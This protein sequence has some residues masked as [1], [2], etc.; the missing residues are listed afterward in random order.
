MISYEGDL[1]NDGFVLVR[2]AV[3]KKIIKEIY[4]EIISSQKQVAK[5][6]QTLKD[7]AQIKSGLA[8]EKNT[9]KYLKN[10]GV[11]FRS[12]NKILQLQTF[13]FAKSIS[14]NELYISDIELHQ[15]SPGVSGTPPHQDNFYFGLKLSKNVALTL[16]FALND[17]EYKSG[18]LSFYPGSHKKCFKHNSSNVIG[19]SSGIKTKDL[20]NFNL[21]TPSLVAGDLVIHHCNIVHTASKNISKK[22]RSNIA[23]RLFPIN[24]KFDKNIQKQYIK[25]RSK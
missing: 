21:Y 23:V 10:P 24:P 18:G 20:D 3:N 4:S 7:T 13:S 11:W 15:K 1:L 5:K 12:V 16:Y 8:L 14:N 17:Q 22:T 6:L 2:N 19:F 25:F 9:I